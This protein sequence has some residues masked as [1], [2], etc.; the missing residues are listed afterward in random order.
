M[1]A[2]ITNNN[3]QIY[4]GS[5]S[6]NNCDYGVRIGDKCNHDVEKRRSTAAASS[7][8]PEQTDRNF[9]EEEVVDDDDIAFN[10]EF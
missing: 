3:P 4:Y 1:T 6:A 8:T 2:A 10:E 9:L 7:R 5:S